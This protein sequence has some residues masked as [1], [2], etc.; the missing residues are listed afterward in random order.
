M[1]DPPRAGGPPQAPAG[2]RCRPLDGAR[3]HRLGRRLAQQDEA[4]GEVRGPRH[5]RVHQGGPR[6]RPAGASRRR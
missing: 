2:Q 6:G 5:P 1:S 4:L 3:G